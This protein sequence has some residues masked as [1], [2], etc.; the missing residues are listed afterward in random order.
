[1]NARREMVE[2]SFNAGSVDVNMKVPTIVSTKPI[3]AGLP[4]VVQKIGVDA[5]VGKR[6]L[7]DIDTDNNESDA[8]A[9]KAKGKGSKQGKAKGKGKGK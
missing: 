6:K 8:K 3:K 7:D 5:K 2:H 1:M 4:V 9:P